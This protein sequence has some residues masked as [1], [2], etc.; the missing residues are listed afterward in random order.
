MS[1]Q[2]SI[3]TG[4]PGLLL[5]SIGV[6]LAVLI[7]EWFVVAR[8]GLQLGQGE[9]ARTLQSLM[10]AALATG[11]GGMV[12]A[13]LA[14]RWIVPTVVAVAAPVAALLFLDLY[15]EFGSQVV[16]AVKL[17][18]AGGFALV[19]FLLLVLVIQKGP[20]WL[21]RAT[22]WWALAAALAALALLL[23]VLN[24]ED[25]TGSWLAAGAVAVA[26]V[27]LLQW[28]RTGHALWPILSVL[29]V[30]AASV[31]LGVRVPLWQP[32]NQFAE[33]KPSVLLVT[34]DTLRADHVGAYGHAEARTP[35]FDALA[36]QGVR[37]S[38][39]VTANVFT[40]PSHSGADA[41][42]YSL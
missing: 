32:A 11:I 29:M 12:V 18:G 41:G 1:A 17:L 31:V 3:R 35:N 16:P 33:G 21:Q 7:V 23:T 24:A 22:G 19:V 15:F 30:L 42:R 40:G 9:I 38:Q 20:A 2:S 36:E 4:L 27:L 39:T 6:A 26:A 34:I 28:R 10:F 25:S 8:L 5:L 37:F 13:T 14:G